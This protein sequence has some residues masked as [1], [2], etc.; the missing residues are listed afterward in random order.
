MANDITTH[1]RL[2]SLTT[3]GAIKAAGNRVFVRHVHYQPAAVDNALVISE[4]GP[5]GATAQN[6]IRMKAGPAVVLP[7]DRHYD[8]PLNLNGFYLSTITAGTVYLTID[9][10]QP[11]ITE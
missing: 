9:K 4:Y 10:V 6:V 3:A 2:W 7:L 8:P 5:D 1:P 11:K